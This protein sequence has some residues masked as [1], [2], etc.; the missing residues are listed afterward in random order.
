[1]MANPC[2]GGEP[3]YVSRLYTPTSAD[4]DKGIVEFVIKTYYKDQHP[5]FPDGDWLSQYMDALEIG[6]TLD[7]RGPSVKIIYKGKGVCLYP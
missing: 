2:T 7:I 5:K 4:D 6:D 1:M 3:K